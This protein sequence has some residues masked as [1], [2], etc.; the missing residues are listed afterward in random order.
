MNDEDD[1]RAIEAVI[2]RQFGAM[3]WSPAAPPDW[4]AFAA[5]FVPGAQLYPAAR[6]AAA[7]SV[8]AFVSRMEGLVESSLPSFA[9]SVL[10]TEIRVFGN[11]AVAMG[12][13]ENVENDTRVVRGIEAFLLVKTGGV[14]QIASQA[15]DT[16]SEVNRVPE[17]FL[18]GK[19]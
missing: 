9:Q 2:T 10:G 14:W 12:A 15:W 3:N 17:R 7:Q 1:I 4:S 8:E 19:A 11:V 6:P 18:G 16:E 13:C 5:D